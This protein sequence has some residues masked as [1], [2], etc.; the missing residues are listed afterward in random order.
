M[1]LQELP[2]LPNMPLRC[3]EVKRAN[4]FENMRLL[5]LSLLAKL[6]FYIGRP[7]RLYDEAK[8]ERP[9]DQAHKAAMA[10][11]AIGDIDHRRRLSRH[12]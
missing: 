6:A 3:A 2:K 7:L 9:H 12:L 10:A 5:Y 11:H 1:S 4:N 8:N